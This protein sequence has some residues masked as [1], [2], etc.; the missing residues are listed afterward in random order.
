MQEYGRHTGIHLEH[1]KG[2]HRTST[3]TERSLRK[4]KTYENYQEIYVT[5]VPCYLYLRSDTDDK[6][7]QDHLKILTIKLSLISKE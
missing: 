4:H 6:T 7:N 1:G 3:Y 5:A 2:N